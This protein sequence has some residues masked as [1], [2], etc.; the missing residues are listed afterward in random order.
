MKNIATRAR[1]LFIV[2]SLCALPAFSQAAQLEL[3]S[4]KEVVVARQLE[5]RSE[6]LDR[7]VSINISLPEHYGQSS[8]DHQYPVVFANDMHG[9][10]FFGIT[11]HVYN[12]LGDVERLPQSIVVSLNGGGGYPAIHHNGMWGERPAEKMQPW[13]NPALYL[14]F[15]E[16]E[17]I[18][19][20]QTEYRANG[21]T[22]LIGVS[23]SAFFPLWVLHEK[24]QL[25]D[26]Y[27]VHA[28][29]DILGM[30]LR[31]DS[32]FYESLPRRLQ[33]YKNPK[34]LKIYISTADSDIGKDSRYNSNLQALQRNLEEID[35]PDIS[36][37]IEI[38]DNGEHYGSYIQ[39]LLG[40]TDYYFPYKDWSA[41]YRDIVKKPGNALKN[42]DNHFD[43]LS[44][45]TGFEILPRADRWHSVNRLGFLVKDLARQDRAA[46][47][48]QVA[49]RYIS[50]QPGS[51]LAYKS[52]AEA[53][54]A[55]HDFERAKSVLEQ[56]LS[57]DDNVAPQLKTQLNELLRELTEDEQIKRKIYR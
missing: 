12:H 32:P 44:G 24:P 50:Y 33:N 37:K 13:G 47:A 8:K 29:A 54:I 5:L 51:P 28:A 55:D 38:F 25:F 52:L 40:A 42:I 48:V 15:F 26:F 31:K 53:L 30:G 46:E 1:S 9:E 14:K 34:P 20:L 49:E 6:T 22:T 36:S 2:Y 3:Q 21:H 35:N 16:K 39:S 4:A 7:N 41:R 10:R 11:S 17:L 19:Y 18:P 57:I 45:K 27:I 23:G 56:A 43:K